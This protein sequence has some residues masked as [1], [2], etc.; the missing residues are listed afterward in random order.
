MPHAAVSSR[1]LCSAWFRTARHCTALHCTALHQLHCTAPVALH[2]TRWFA[3]TKAQL[4]PRTP[5]VQ[6]GAG[7]YSRA[8]SQK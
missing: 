7:A 6:L 3:L 4:A 1:A 2:C 8:T 5:P